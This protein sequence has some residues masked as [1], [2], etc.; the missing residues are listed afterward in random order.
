M[1]ANMVVVATRYVRRLLPTT[2]GSGYGATAPARRV[3]CICSALTPLRPRHYDY[4]LRGY[5]GYDYGMATTTNNSP[6]P[7]KSF[8][9]RHVDV[10]SPER[11]R[12]SI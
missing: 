8:N 12:F 3:G 6:T 11:P 10:E 4:G 7:T 2:A 9:A 5:G 1:P